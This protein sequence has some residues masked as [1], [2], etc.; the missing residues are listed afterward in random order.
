MG[1]GKWQRWVNHLSH[2]GGIPAPSDA[3]QCTHSLARPIICSVC[4]SGG[5][6]PSGCL[7]GWVIKRDA[8]HSKDFFRVGMGISAN[9]LLAEAPL[10]PSMVSWKSRK[11]PVPDIRS[12]FPCTIFHKRTDD[13]I[14]VHHPPRCDVVF[15]K[16]DLSLQYSAGRW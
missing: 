13:R 6:F 11:W 15:Q 3:L 5:I 10:S 12:S 8:D 2:T 16:L 14:Y 4:T 9:T 1:W 7:I